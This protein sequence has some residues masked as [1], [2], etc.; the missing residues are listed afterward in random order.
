MDKTKK[1]LDT[2]LVRESHILSSIPKF[3]PFKLTPTPLQLTT[4]TET[5]DVCLIAAICRL[6]APVNTIDVTGRLALHMAAAAANVP[7]LHILLR[8]GADPNATDENGNTALHSLLDI[9]PQPRRASTGPKP[10]A[11]TATPG[12]LHDLEK[13]LHASAIGNDDNDDEDTFHALRLLL[14]NGAKPGIK[15]AEGETALHLAVQNE[16][17]RTAYVL[18]SFGAPVN[19]QDKYG[20][21]ALHHAAVQFHSPYFRGSPLRVPL[22]RLVNENI[23]VFHVEERLAGLG[24]PRKLDRNGVFWGSEMVWLLVAIAEAEEGMKTSKGERAGDWVEFGI[25]LRF[26]R[27]D[28]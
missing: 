10:R 21:T 1:A 3:L 7:V 14:R 25:G 16:D 19:A 18:I 15:N 8:H 23:L 11:Y 26:G 4:A 13:S 20:Y 9:P 5:G 28:I 24:S 2:P 22:V 6:H 12:E 17:L 27:G